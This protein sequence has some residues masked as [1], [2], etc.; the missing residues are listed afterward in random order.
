MWRIAEEVSMFY[1]K[2]LNDTTRQ[3]LNI[4]SSLLTSTM[5]TLTLKC[6]HDC[7][8]DP[9]TKETIAPHFVA[10]CDDLCNYLADVVAKDK[11]GDSEPK[12]YVVLAAIAKKD[13]QKTRI[14][15]KKASKS[16]ARAA[17]KLKRVSQQ[18]GESGTPAVVEAKEAL[19][20]ANNALSKAESAFKQAE[21]CVKD[22]TER[23]DESI[24]IR[25][26]VIKCWSKPLGQLVKAASHP[27]PGC[28]QSCRIILPRGSKISDQQQCTCTCAQII[29]TGFSGSDIIR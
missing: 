18:T 4:N 14:H 2:T 27:I 3:T 25:S 29:H 26:L 17:K 20:K 24:K 9:F 10:D 11:F 7:I 6:A 13:V 19:T 5:P 15:V 28:V 21:Q 22:A 1:T 12:L 16:V 23:A 8:V